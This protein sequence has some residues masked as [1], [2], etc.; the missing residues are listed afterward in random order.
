M[1]RCEAPNDAE[2]TLDACV[3]AKRFAP[4]MKG[5]VCHPDLRCVETPRI[6]SRS[7]VY[8]NV[9]QPFRSLPALGYEPAVC[10]ASLSVSV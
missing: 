1:Y 7:N 4:W 10:R 6:L 5:V 8:T 3:I 9:S 2:K